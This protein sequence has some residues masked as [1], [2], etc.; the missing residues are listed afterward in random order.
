VPIQQALEKRLEVAMVDIKELLEAGVQP[1][2][3]VCR[4]SHP[5]TP[6]IRQ[7]IASF[8][9]VEQ[10]AVIEAIDRSIAKKNRRQP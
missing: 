4:T 8:C 3:L 7:K 5:I 1:D 2:I 6:E 9:N 10:E